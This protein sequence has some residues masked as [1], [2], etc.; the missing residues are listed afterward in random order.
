MAPTDPSAASRLLVNPEWLDVPLHPLA[1]LGDSDESAQLPY[2]CL[3]PNNE[4][5]MRDVIREQFVPFVRRIDAESVAKM[6]R[7]F[8]Y[9]LSSTGVAWGSVFDAV[10]MPFEHP[11]NPRDFFVW[12]WEECFPGESWQF[13]DLD[14]YIVKRDLEEP[15]RSIKLAPV[16]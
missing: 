15:N 6:K 16:P 7:A 9:Y 11:G 12:V 10:Y 4:Q 1:G 2:I 13:D 14:R 3:D 8:K 5:Q